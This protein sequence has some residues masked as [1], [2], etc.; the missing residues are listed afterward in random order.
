MSRHNVDAFTINRAVWIILHWFMVLYI[1]IY[2]VHT[3]HAYRAE[4]LSVLWARWWPRV[5]QSEHCRE[6]TLCLPL[7][8]VCVSGEMETVLP[9]DKSCYSTCV[10]KVIVFQGK[11]WCMPGVRDKLM[12]RWKWCK[13]SILASV[14]NRSIHT[15]W[16]GMARGLSS[17]SHS[18]CFCSFF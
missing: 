8:V 13:V 15:A 12:P 10:G 2:R 5:V 17:R 3:K 7:S 18:S 6:T 16:P 14:Q 4:F 11:R 1:Y 9:K